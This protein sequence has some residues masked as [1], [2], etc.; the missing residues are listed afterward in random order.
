MIP[1]YYRIKKFRKR[2]S[3][4]SS[5]GSLIGWN[6][7]SLQMRFPIFVGETIPPFLNGLCSGSSV[8]SREKRSREPNLKL[9]GCPDV[10]VNRFNLADMCPHGPVNTRASDAQKHAAGESKLD[11]C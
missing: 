8:K 2:L 10:E 3:V 7:A 5:A 11:R 9:G 6:M 4:V 1:S